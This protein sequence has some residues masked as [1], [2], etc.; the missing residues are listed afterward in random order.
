MVRFFF[1]FSIYIPQLDVAGG[2]TT[3]CRAA[4]GVLAGKLTVFVTQN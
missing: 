3:R 1:G 2:G 4:G